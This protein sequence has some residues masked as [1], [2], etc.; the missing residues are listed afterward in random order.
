MSKAQSKLILL[1][2]MFV[3]AILVANTVASKLFMVGSFVMTAGIIAY[4]ITFL[5]TDIVNE[6]WGKEVAQ[7]VVM[8]GFAA[9][10]L[11]V[12]LYQISVILPVGGVWEGQASFQAVLGAVPRIVLASMVAYLISQHWDVWVFN[13]VKEK[14][15]Y[16]LWLR[17]NVSTITSQAIDSAIFL[18]IAFGGTLPFDM[19]VGMFVSYI[20]VKWAIALLDTPFC[21]LGVAW[22]RKGR[23]DGY[24][25]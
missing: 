15:P 7:R 9:N 10:I 1:V 5:I 21:Y 23:H 4:P 22:A 25:F 13:L 24:P 17:N 11:M 6:V 14:L 20:V 12:L 8:I 2:G 16:G 19:L 18:A 3:T